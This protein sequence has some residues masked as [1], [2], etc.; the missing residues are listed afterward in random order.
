MTYN[1]KQR[2][3]LD[4]VSEL[5]RQ[6]VLTGSKAH[7]YQLVTI[8]FRKRG[9]AISPRSLYRWE[10]EWMALGPCFAMLAAPIKRRRKEK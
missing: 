6:M 10:K 7:A 8:E 3:K 5:R 9:M 2:L 4:A 1:E